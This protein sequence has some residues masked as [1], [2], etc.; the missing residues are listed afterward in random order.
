M[1]NYPLGWQ[2]WS[3]P[4]PSLLK[5][6]YWDYCPLP[7]SPHPYS[8]PQEHKLPITL[9]CSWH[10]FYKNIS[11]NKIL[12]QAQKFRSHKYVPQYILIDDGWCTWGD[13]ITPSQSK[14]PSGLNSI[15]QRL[16]KLNYK[17]GLW[18]APFLVDPKSKLMQEHPDWIIHRN[19]YSTYPLVMD[20]TPKYLLDYQNPEVIQYLY[21]T[22]DTIITQWGISLLKLDFLYAPYFYPGLKDDSL[23][24]QVLVN[25][26]AYLQTTYPHVY[27]IACGCPFLP[28]RGK[29]DAIRISKDINFPATNYLRRHLLWNKLSLARK[30]APLPFGLDPD[31]SLSLAEADI[32]HKLYLDGQIQVFG[33]GYAL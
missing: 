29:V 28:A 30:L 12:D 24:H 21:R 17:T 20:L 4:T 27:T 1:Q 13:W 22:L 10:H 7:Q 15:T 25:L 6:P 2:S 5:L 3:P 14:F 16:N 19:C 32:Y 18:L 33:L 31:V 23:P 26:F 11:E 8:Q 9:W